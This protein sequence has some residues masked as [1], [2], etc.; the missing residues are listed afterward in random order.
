MKISIGW[1]N[2]G[3]QAQNAA[4]IHQINTK[5]QL[6]LVQIKDVIFPHLDS[7][8]PN[9]LTMNTDCIFQRLKKLAEIW[10]LTIV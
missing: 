7:R 9:T 8:N 3:Y 4:Q 5:L 1:Q 2:H 10:A 6:E